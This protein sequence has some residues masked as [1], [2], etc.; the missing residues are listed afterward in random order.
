MFSIIVLSV[1]VAL[2]FCLL[3][4]EIARLAKRVRAL[5]RTWR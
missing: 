4:M 1:A 3:E 2:G 5:E